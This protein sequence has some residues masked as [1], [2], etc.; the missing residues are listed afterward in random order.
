MDKRPQKTTNTQLLLLKAGS[1]NQGAGSKNRVLSMCVCMH[2]C[3]EYV[4]ICVSGGLNLRLQSRVSS[5]DGPAEAGSWPGDHPLAAA[6]CCRLW[7]SGCCRAGAGSSPPNPSWPGGAAQHTRN[8]T[9][10]WDNSRPAQNWASWSE[11]PSSRGA[12]EMHT[13]PPSSS[14]AFSISPRL[15]ASGC[16]HCPLPRLTHAVPVTN[17]W[18]STCTIK[19]ST[20]SLHCLRVSGGFKKLSFQKQHWIIFSGV[21]VGSGQAN[22]YVF[23]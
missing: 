7:C 15:I 23:S 21:T 19:H 20:A 22:R 17:G 16:A 3:T 2:A 14:A 10:P 18:T 4:C 11:V 13:V 8:Q 5:L 6:V 9:L 12:A 1:K